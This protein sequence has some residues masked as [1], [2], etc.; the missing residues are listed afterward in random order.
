[1]E[2][3]KLQ[4]LFRGQ[5]VAIKYTAEFKRE[6]PHTTEIFDGKTGTI[7]DFISDAGGVALVAIKIPFF[8]VETLVDRRHVRPI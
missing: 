4:T 3:T 8:K 6:Y 5:L 7:T 1:M 2:K